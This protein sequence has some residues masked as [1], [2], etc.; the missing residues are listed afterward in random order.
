MAMFIAWEAQ[1]GSFAAK[2]SDGNRIASFAVAIVIFCQSYQTD[3]IA[4]Y[5]QKT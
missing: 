3:H 5:Y 2:S 1:A 4:R